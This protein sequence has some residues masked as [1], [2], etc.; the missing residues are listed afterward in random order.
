[1]VANKK[2]GATA[3]VAPSKPNTAPNIEDLG[4]LM[5]SLKTT[6]EEEYASL[7]KI[8]FK[9]MSEA[10]Q[11]E[12][13]KTLTQG[14]MLILKVIMLKYVEELKEKGKEHGLSSKVMTF[15]MELENDEKSRD[16]MENGEVTDEVV[17]LDDDDVDDDKMREDLLRNKSLRRQL[18]IFMPCEQYFSVWQSDLL[19][20]MSDHVADE[21]LTEDEERYFRWEK[22]GNTR[23][24][25]AGR[26]CTHTLKLTSRSS[27]T[28]SRR[29][30]PGT[31]MSLP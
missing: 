16:T 17:D 9:S 14:Q 15:L 8:D 27:S 21:N 22:P 6:E 23:P 10:E 20:G 3:E 13:I 26:L 28:L 2:G 18:A 19:K 30:P 29:K 1:M 31:T 7:E 24:T 4:A 12:K 11:L 5:K 25:S